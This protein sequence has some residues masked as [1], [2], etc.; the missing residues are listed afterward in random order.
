[1]GPPCDPCLTPSL[2]QL[3]GQGTKRVGEGSPRS[4]SPKRRRE[5]DDEEVQLKE[6]FPVEGVSGKVVSSHNDQIGE[7]VVADTRKGNIEVLFH[8]NQVQG[9]YHNLLYFHRFP[10]A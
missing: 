5:D 10:L 8:V 4:A 3:T 9:I 6:V 2:P 1:M 7:I